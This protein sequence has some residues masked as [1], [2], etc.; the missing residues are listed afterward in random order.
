MNAY[1]VSSAS[2]LCVVRLS[3]SFA[4]PCNT[5]LDFECPEIQS[6]SSRLIQS[7]LSFKSH[8]GRYTIHHA[9]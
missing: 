5:R 7:F 3:N 8:G 2:K 1:I 9:A 4:I 6:A